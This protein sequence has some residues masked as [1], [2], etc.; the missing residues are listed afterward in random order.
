MATHVHGHIDEKYV[1]NQHLNSFQ[2]NPPTAPVWKN[3][4]VIAAEKEKL[5]F[6]ESGC[7]NFN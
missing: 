4:G 2:W 7:Y 6:S 5:Q 1:I 3:Y